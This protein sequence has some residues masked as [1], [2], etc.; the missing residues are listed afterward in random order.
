MRFKGFTFWCNPFSI[1]VLSEVSTADYTLP[2]SGQEYEDLGK[3]CRVIKGKGEIRGTDC[4]EKYAELY[5]LLSK[6]GKGVLSLP[7]MKPMEALF[8]S[9]SALADVSPD[10]ISYSFTFTEVNSKEKKP[11]LKT[12]TVKSG[13]T[14][15]DIAY[16]YDVS[17]ESLVE[18]NPNIRRPDEL[19][20][21]WEI[22]VC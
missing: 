11:F 15:F 14:L 1:E 18:L 8:T 7:N 10:K 4:L 6:P 13:E 12:H 2:Y 5:A 20:E 17:V 19:L 9:L 16:K 3:K 21:G 22:K